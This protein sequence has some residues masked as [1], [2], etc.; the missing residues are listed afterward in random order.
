MK[1]SC[2]VMKLI[3]DAGL[4]PL[5]VIRELGGQ[6]TVNLDTVER[7]VYNTAVGDRLEFVAERDGEEFT[8]EIISK[9]L[10]Q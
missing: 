9:E 10:A 2:A 5:G 7:L 1:P 6:P 8:G 3:L 4:R